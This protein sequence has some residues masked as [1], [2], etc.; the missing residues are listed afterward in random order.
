MDAQAQLDGFIDKYS[1]E[2]AAD[3]RWA[4]AFLT[5]R[6]PAATRLVYDNYNAL[7]IGFGASD[8]ASDAILSIALYPSYL[9]LFLLDGASLP[10]PGGILEGGGSRV[11]H[12]KLRPVSRLETA[13][14][15]ALMDAAIAAA[16]IPLPNGSE[17]PLII[18]SV[19][20]QQRP[21]RPN[22]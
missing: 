13:E 9:S 5:A 2:V 19:S 3:A 11:R 20:A 22:S 1:P 6:F 8:R 18:K 17:G 15:L 14:V 10:D 7:A 4:L 16:R 12:V 21:R